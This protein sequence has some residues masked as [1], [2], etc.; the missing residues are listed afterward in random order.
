MLGV[1]LSV[2][3]TAQWSLVKGGRGPLLAG[4]RMPDMELHGGEAV[5]TGCTI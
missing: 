3:E 4:D 5:R 1:R 2:D